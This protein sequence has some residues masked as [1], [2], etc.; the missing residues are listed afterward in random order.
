MPTALLEV[1]MSQSHT[2]FSC[3]PHTRQTRESLPR[4]E[5]SACATHRQVFCAVLEALE[6]TDPLR[7]GPRRP[8][9]YR[10]AAT[11]IT[12]ALLAGTG[13][14]AQPVLAALEPC[15]IVSR[16]HLGRLLGWLR[17]EPALERI[18]PPPQ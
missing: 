5:P 18:S 11:S 10:P 2:S 1:I 16:Y 9:Y 14:T 7:V 3:S 12:T 8:D 15:G 17:L 4:Q 13:I 6:G